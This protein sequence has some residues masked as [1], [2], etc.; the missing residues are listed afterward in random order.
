MF[1]ITQSKTYKHEVTITLPNEEG[2]APKEHKFTAIFHRHGVSKVEALMQECKDDK[3][4]ARAVLA[5]WEGVQEEY[6]E[7]NVEALLD[8]VTVAGQISKAF[9]A[10]IAGQAEKN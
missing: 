10:S 6:N 2:G 7:Q 1:V 5:G 4:L 3:A 9:L 8:L